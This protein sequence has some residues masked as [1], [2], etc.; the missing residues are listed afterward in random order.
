VCEIGTRFS[1]ELLEAAYAPTVLAFGF[2]GGPASIA[3]IPRQPRDSASPSFD[4]YALSSVPVLL[5]IGF[6]RYALK[7]GMRTIPRAEQQQQKK[8]PT[9]R[10]CLVDFAGGPAGMA[11]I[12]PVAP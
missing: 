12:P 6:I 4:G 8:P 2:A 10:P 9:Y 3:D 1:P 11:D 5:S 7:R